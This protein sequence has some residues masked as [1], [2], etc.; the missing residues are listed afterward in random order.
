MVGFGCSGI[1]LH[2]AVTSIAGTHRYRSEQDFSLCLLSPDDIEGIRDRG[3]NPV[4]FST[5][6]RC[7]Y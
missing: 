4:H 2:T 5:E 7:G 1:L 6:G 3:R